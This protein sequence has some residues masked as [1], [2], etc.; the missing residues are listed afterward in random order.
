MKTTAEIISVG[1][2]LLLGDIVNT[3]AHYLSQN[4]AHL[5]IDLY[6]Q[7]TVGDNG[8]R[9]HQ[10][11][12]IA[13]TRANLVILTGGLGPTKD[14][15]TK[16]TLASYFQKELVLDTKAYEKL[17]ERA[18]LY[19]LKSVSQSNKK[20]AYVPQGAIVLYNDNG[21]APGFIIEGAKQGDDLQTAILLPGPPREMQPMF[22]TYCIPYLKRRSDKVLVSY[23]IRL[24]RY[25]TAERKDVGESPVADKITHLLDNKNPTVATYAK[26]DGVRIRVTA[27]A[28]EKKEALF[29][30]NP[31]IEEIKK[32]LGDVI[33]EICE[34]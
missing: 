27:T 31:V 19:G 9:L 22:E 17:E 1:T 20:Q 23:N 21:T 8:E 29:L 34:I 11:L 6:F 10:A 2:E 3:N 5:G 12:E 7:T 32:C 15:L 25:G 26:E 4:L 30:I 14:D 16:E 33:E 28:T 13:F 18:R 24:K